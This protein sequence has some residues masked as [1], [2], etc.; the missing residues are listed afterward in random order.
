MVNAC[1][2]SDGPGFE[3]YPAA[4][5]RRLGMAGSL[6]GSLEPLGVGRV[7]LGMGSQR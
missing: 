7:G 3:S 6:R 2:H 5:V 4:V 1:A